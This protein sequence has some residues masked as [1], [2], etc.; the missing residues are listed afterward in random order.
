MNIIGI[1]AENVKKL[2][3]INLHFDPKK[4]KRRE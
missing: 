2:K 1:T 3:L 4:P